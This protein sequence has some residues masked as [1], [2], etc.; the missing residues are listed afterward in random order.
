MKKKSSLFLLLAILLVTNL[1]SYTMG[2]SLSGRNSAVLSKNGELDNEQ[3]RRL[4]FEYDVRLSIK[5]Y[6]ANPI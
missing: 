5:L 4:L 2:R 3:K 6:F 1:T